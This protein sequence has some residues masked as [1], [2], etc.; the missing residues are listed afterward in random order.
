MPNWIERFLARALALTTIV[1]VVAVEANAASFTENLQGE[2]SGSGEITL[3]S[4]KSERIRCRGLGRAVSE[5]T[6]EQQF[7]CASTDKDF[8]F[9]TSIRVSEGRAQGE[10][11]A[12]DRSGT[13][14]G[15]ASASSMKLH[16][17]SASGEGDLSATIGACSQ[18]LRV[19]GWSNELKSMSVNL[20][21]EC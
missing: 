7:F 12:P 10:W 19:T 5:N 11:K 1:T 13:L 9:F 21:K 17:S 18:S 4:G 3:V 6:I 16:L 15:S 2:W 14:S 8:N 20:E